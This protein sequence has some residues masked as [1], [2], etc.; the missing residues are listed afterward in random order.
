SRVSILTG[1]S[2]K[3]VRHQRELLQ[4]SESARAGKPHDA[5]RLLSGWFQDPAYLDGR[6][7]PLALVERGE[8]PSFESL[9]H[10]YGGDT[11]FQTL[12]KEL[13]VAGTIAVDDQGRLVAK[14]RYHM[15]VPMSEGNIRFFGANLFD[16]ARTLEQNITGSAQQRKFEGFAVDD[17]LNPDVA[18]EFHEFLNERG[19]QFL[20]EVDGWLN[21]HR[22]AESNVESI[23]IRLGVG[24]YAIDGPLPEGKQS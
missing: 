21:D 15:P 3:E 5:T 22:V 14:S 24:I 16:H 2:R 12:M 17:R 9:F 6:G 8:V 19:Q 18:A 23:P 20:E 7:L 1:I 13:K 4:G 10:R 11:P